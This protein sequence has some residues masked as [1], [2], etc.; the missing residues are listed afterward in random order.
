MEY[1]TT[2]RT[3]PSGTI[4]SI[5]ENNEKLKITAAGYFNIINELITNKE[6]EDPI[7]PIDPIYNN[8]TEHIKVL[9]ETIKSS[10]NPDEETIIKENKSLYK[11]I[12]E[13]ENKIDC[14]LKIIKNFDEKFGIT[15]F[16][17]NLYDSRTKIKR[18]LDRKKFY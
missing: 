4:K 15:P 16:Y 6:K 17:N 7:T 14:L 11:G 8:I 10:N 3:Y 9:K 5:Q 1:E 12:S 2:K 18:L 13:F